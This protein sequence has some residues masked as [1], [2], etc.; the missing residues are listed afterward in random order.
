M[1]SSD[2]LQ[3]RH[4]KRIGIMT[5]GGDAPGMNM[6]LRCVVR[7]ALQHDFEVIGIEN[8]YSGMLKK[9]FR[10]LNA[11]D[12]GYIMQRG[13][14]MLGTARSEYFKTAQGRAEALAN[15][16]EAEIEALVIIGGNGSLTGGLELERAGMPV[17][18]IPGSIDNDLYG[19]QMAIGVDTCLNTIVDA[20]DR[21]K[22]TAAAH[23][24]A[25]VV[26]VMGRHSG[27]LALMGALAS[28]AEVAVIPEVQ[29]SLL[30]IGNKMEKAFERGKSHFIVMV[31]EGASLKAEE[32][33]T[34]LSQFD[35]HETRITILGHLQRGGAPSAYD[36][37]LASY[38]GIKAVECLLEGHTGVMVG[39][40]DGK[41]VRTPLEQ[42]VKRNS[43]V[44]MQVYDMVHLLS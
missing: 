8:G 25:F 15:L 29:S 6:T 17:V 41:F 3:T 14:T 40:I 43:S 34:Y 33:H 10:P 11:H 18:G 39:Q 35:H 4:F 32:I 31:A 21:I 44:N 2:S 19:T 42:V 24:R 16:H 28:G 12:V 9:Q 22:D 37:I 27:Y 13:G 38:L 26:E 5:S 30:D 20:V 36:R 7:A 23:H 1:P